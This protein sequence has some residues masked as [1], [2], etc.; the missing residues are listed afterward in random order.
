MSGILVVE[1]QGDIANLVRMH[2]EMLGHRVQCC[3]TLSFARRA[4]ASDTWDLLVLDQGV[5]RTRQPLKLFMITG[6]A[7]IAKSD[8]LFYAVQA[9]GRELVPG[10]SAD[11][12][13]NAP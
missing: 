12:P 1:D 7:D 9:D 4:L 6:N 5:L 8:C 3:D 13:D 10:D 2:V 11:G